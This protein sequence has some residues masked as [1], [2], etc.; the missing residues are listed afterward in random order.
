MGGRLQTDHL[1][2]QGARR[3]LG[4]GDARL[5]P[6]Q[7]RRHGRPRVV[8]RRR[9][10]LADR[11]DLR[12]APPRRRPRHGQARDA[13]YAG[14]LGVTNWRPRPVD[15]QW[16]NDGVAAASSDGGPLVVRGPDSSR[17]LSD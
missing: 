17:V 2:E 14:E 15:T 10:L 8:A 5:E 9:R 6:V 13:R 7:A 3:L 16:R 11:D 4:D 12:V 1:D